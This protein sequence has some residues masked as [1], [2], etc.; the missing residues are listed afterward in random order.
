MLLALL[1]VLLALLQVL[2]PGG[3]ELLPALWG[4]LLAPS[5]LLQELLLARRGRLP[6]LPSRSW[7]V[8]EA[9]LVLASKGWML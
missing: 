2:L 6:Q 9:L 5:P 7:L 4:L 8:W 3:W 1:Q